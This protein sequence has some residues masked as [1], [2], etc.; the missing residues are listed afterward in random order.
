MAGEPSPSAAAHWAPPPEAAER[1]RGVGEILAEA[2]ATY[3]RKAAPLLMLSLI[4][5]GV[6]TLIALPYTIGAGGQTL[7]LV[8]SGI[9]AIDGGHRAF[10]GLPRL[11]TDPAMAALGGALSVVPFAG[12]LMLIAASTAL[13][14]APQPEAR[15]WRGSLGRA[16][17]QRVPIL[18][19]IIALAILAALIQLPIAGLAGQTADAAAGRTGVSSQMILVAFLLAA[20]APALIIAAAYLAVRWA[21]AV[22]VLVMEG[23]TL[24]R[25]L[26]RSV[27]LTRRRTLHVGLALLAAYGG[28]AILGAIV[29]TVTLVVTASLVAVRASPILFAVPIA[30]HV[31]TRVLLAPIGA[32]VPVL[33]YR[34]L[35]L[36]SDASSSARR[37]S[38][39]GPD[40]RRSAGVP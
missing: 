16:L 37:T 17:E 1:R 23:A 4:T 27:L 2:I 25:A 15:T 7:E 29:T 19:P 36:S 33:L 24:R 14:L 40:P 38:N 30:V 9:A 20:T 13:L 34:D 35:R 26:A 28:T 22:P 12:T 3:K 21:V 11:L 5:E 18:A 31:V 6:V 39:T 32:V 10:V 8:Q